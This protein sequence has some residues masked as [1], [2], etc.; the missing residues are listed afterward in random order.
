MADIDRK[1]D[2]EMN[3]VDRTSQQSAIVDTVS[4]SL[5]GIDTAHSEIHAGDHFYINGFQDVSGLS[6]TVGFAFNVPDTTKR[7]HALWTLEAEDEFSFYMYE[8]AIFATNGTA[9]P[10][11]NNNRNSANS[12]TV[13]GFAN[14]TVATLGSLVWSGKVGSVHKLGGAVR[15]DSEFIGKQNSKYY[16]KIVHEANTTAWVAFNFFWYEHT[17]E[18]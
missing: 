13:Q 1:G 7:P 17:D 3:I 12:S 9:V 18:V 5:I 6:T 10:A 16:F 4:S 2:Q 8:D 15:S 11:H 14:P